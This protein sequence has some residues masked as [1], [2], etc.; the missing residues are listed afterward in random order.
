[1]PGN[2]TTTFAH[3]PVFT[4]IRDVSVNDVIATTELPEATNCQNF[5]RVHLQII[6]SGGVLATVQMYSWSDEADAFIVSEPAITF[7]PT[8][9]E[10]TRVVNVNSQFVFFAVTSIPASETVKL[11]VAGVN[12][13]TMAH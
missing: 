1:M 3:A 8:A 6:Q 12:T 7:T 10:S 2:I 5:D 13:R 9:L 4:T 11:A